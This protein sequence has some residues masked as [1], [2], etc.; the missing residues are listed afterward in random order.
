[1]SLK[2]RLL[3]IGGCFVALCFNA[4][5]HNAQA[6]KPAVVFSY[7]MVPRSVVFVRSL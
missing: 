2:S 6:Y 7:E 1:M 5:F 3:P 4:V